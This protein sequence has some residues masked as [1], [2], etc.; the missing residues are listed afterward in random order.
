MA[1]SARVLAKCGFRQE[2]IAEDYLYINGKWERHILNSL[3]SK[4]W[5]ETEGKK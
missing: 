5:I 2:G 1:F 4:D 3:I